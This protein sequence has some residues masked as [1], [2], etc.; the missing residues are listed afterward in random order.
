MVVEG[1][2]INT[3]VGVEAVEEVVEATKMGAT[4][5]MNNLEIIIQEATITQEVEPVGEVVG[6]PPTIMD[7]LLNQVTVRP[8]HRFV[9]LFFRC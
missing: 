9:S 5:T 7:P 1:V 8:M 6:T 2:V 3:A 4:N